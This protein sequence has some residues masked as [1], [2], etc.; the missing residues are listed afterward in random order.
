MQ[1]K[2]TTYSVCLL[3]A[4]F[5][6]N[7]LP[8]VYKWCGECKQTQTVMVAFNHGENDQMMVYCIDQN[9]KSHPTSP[10]NQN[11]DSR[12]KSNDESASPCLLCTL[13]TTQKQSQ[14]TGLTLTN[15]TPV[16][17]HK[18]HFTFFY[19][20]SNNLSNPNITRGPPSV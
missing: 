4:T 17:F 2:I 12:S 8:F 16:I 1:K 5:A 11:N 13:A 14:T 3:F 6:T 20:T 19:S 15:E 9:G 7:A 10:N 18:T